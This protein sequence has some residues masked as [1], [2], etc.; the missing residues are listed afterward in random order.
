MSTVLNYYI[1]IG[2]DKTNSDNN[3]IKPEE[4]KDILHK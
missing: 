1:L 2:F 3:S 4:L